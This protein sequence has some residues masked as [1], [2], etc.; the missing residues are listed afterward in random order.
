ML[1]SDTPNYSF[2]TTNF[3]GPLDVLLRLIER[4]ELDITAVALAQVADQYLAHVR[5]L[6]APD[7]SAVSAFL[8]VAARLVL[9]KSRALL[10]HPA[11]KPHGAAIDEAE[12]LVR[13]L[14]EYQR[15]KQAAALLRGLQERGLRTYTRQTPL[16]LPELPAGKIDS[17]LGDML[18]AIQRRLELVRPLDE[19]AVALPTRKIIT[20]P[21]MAARIEQRLISQQWIDF[22][23]LLSAATSRV[24]VVV[25]LWTVLEL[26]KRRVV[27]VEQQVVFGR[28]AIGRGP[29]GAGELHTLAAEV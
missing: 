13:Q 5:A 26:L 10:P 8:V 18:A 16:P 12:E 27:V 22:E 20:V 6:A 24:E 29:V 19:P 28:I 17:T 14:K 11:A 15:F 9:I 7:P 1:F 23:D 25:A 21:E 3:E 4:E 2:T